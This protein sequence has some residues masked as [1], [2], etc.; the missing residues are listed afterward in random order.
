MRCAMLNDKKRENMYFNCRMRKKEVDKKLRVVRAALLVPPALMLA[1]AVIEI[2]MSTLGET[3]IL[4]SGAAYA[5]GYDFVGIGLLPLFNIIISG[6]ICFVVVNLTIFN[7]DWAK[8]SGIIIYSG[9][10][11]VFLIITLF[12]NLAFAFLFYIAYFAIG[13]ALI[14][15]F[16]QVKKEDDE[17][18]RLDGYPHFNS[19]LIKNT[20]EPYITKEDAG[21]EDMTPEERIMFERG[22]R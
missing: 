5:F 6:A 9:G 13:I 11:I 10:L 7:S 2:I 20:D 17:L 14:W 21:Y 15:A 12:F 8:R 19:L 3:V 1:S 4:V 22:Q 18:S 16:K